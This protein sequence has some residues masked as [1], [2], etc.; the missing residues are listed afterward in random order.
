MIN[1]HLIYVHIP[2]INVILIE[3][4]VF[5]KVSIGFLETILVAFRYFVIID[6]WKDQVFVHLLHVARDSEFLCPGVLKLGH[7][8]DGILDVRYSITF[9][10][11]DVHRQK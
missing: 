10:L 7:C 9:E 2:L 1:F 4:G 11:F 5:L 6:N 3:D 8:V